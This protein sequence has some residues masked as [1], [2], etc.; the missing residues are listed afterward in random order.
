MIMMTKLK[1]ASWNNA[2][3]IESVRIHSI[4][5]SDVFAYVA[6]VVS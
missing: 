1:E 5:L 4:E 2:E 6:V 3:E